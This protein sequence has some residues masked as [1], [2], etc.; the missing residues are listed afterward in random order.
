MFD[1]THKNAAIRAV[2]LISIFIL[3]FATP[4]SAWLSGYGY[5]QTINVTG[6]VSWTSNLTNYQ[7][8]FQVFNTSGTS[9]GSV[10]YTNGTTQT[11]WDV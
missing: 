6:N 10:L 7:V 1:T 9:S 3:F 4:S 5:N 8:M 2:I 11:D